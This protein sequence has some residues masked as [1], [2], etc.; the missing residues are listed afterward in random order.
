M[1]QP[2]NSCNLLQQFCSSGNVRAMVKQGG[3]ETAEKDGSKLVNVAYSRCCFICQCLLA[4]ATL[5]AGVIIP[6]PLLVDCLDF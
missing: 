3:S 5:R 1:W 2:C 4:A 6:T